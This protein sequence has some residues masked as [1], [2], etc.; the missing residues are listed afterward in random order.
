M[1]YLAKDMNN[2]QFK[3]DII[4]YNK[5]GEIVGVATIKDFWSIS[6]IESITEISEKRIWPLETVE[7]ANVLTKPEY[8]EKLEV[9]QYWHNPIHGDERLMVSDLGSGLFENVCTKS[10]T[11]PTTN[12]IGKKFNDTISY[13]KIAGYLPGRHPSNR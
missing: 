1:K 2:N 13:L 6:E 12:K 5:D 7:P 8:P 9:G 4:C 3:A 11:E 10:A